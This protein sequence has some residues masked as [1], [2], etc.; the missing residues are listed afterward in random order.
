[1]APHHRQQSYYGYSFESFCTSSLPNQAETLPG[2]PP[3]W[4]G[5]VNTNVQWCSVVKTKLASHRLLIGGEVDC[6]RGMPFI[7]HVLYSTQSVGIV[8]KQDHRSTSDY[9]PDNYVELK[10]NLPIR[11]PHDEVKFERCIISY[12]HF[13]LNSDWLQK[14]AQV[15]L[16][17][18]S[19]RRPGK[20]H[21]I[22]SFTKL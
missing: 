9:K 13:H 12:T 14:N 1:M 10:T 16:S 17:V 22:D 18:V 4:S 2:H 21:D 5:D 3:G 11:G 15:L 19:P 6:V 7:V 8:A 20:Y